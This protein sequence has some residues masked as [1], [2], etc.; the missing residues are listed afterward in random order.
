MDLG[1]ALVFWWLCL[2]LAACQRPLGRFEYV[3]LQSQ[4]EHTALRYGVYLPRGWDRRTPLPLVVLLHGAGDDASSADR[5]QVVEAL[6][7][8]QAHGWLRPFVMV[9]PD[10]RVGFWSNWYDGSHHFRDWVVREVIPD[11][12]RRFALLPAPEG[13]HLLGVSMGAGGGLQLWLQT[14]GTFA[15]ASLL[16]API[17]DE[18]G[19]RAFLRRFAPDALIQR[20]FGPP[21]RATGV[22]PYAALK[23][24][25]DLH[26]TRLLFGAALSD[27][28]GILAAN[29]AFHTTLVQRQV[30]HTLVTFPGRH[31]W[32]AW[33]E[34]F[35]HVLCAQIDPDCRRPATSSISWS[36]R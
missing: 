10:G 1:R 8:A 36:G 33:A 6:D 4:S 35:P 34:V 7:A 29:R 3:T 2:L 30:P 11:A 27:K 25:Q 17:L 13:L 12:Y 20:V 15:S 19:T 22:D 16:S 26:G 14:P 5:R 18:A 32:R 21:G 24:A 28:A 31:G 23:R 9:A